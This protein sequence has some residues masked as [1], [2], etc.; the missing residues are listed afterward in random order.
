MSVWCA[1]LAVAALAMTA[2][3]KSDGNDGL[4]W[5]FAGCSI[6]FALLAAGNAY[7]DRMQQ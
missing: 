1:V 5:Y 2:Y 7:L 3:T 6:L 4:A